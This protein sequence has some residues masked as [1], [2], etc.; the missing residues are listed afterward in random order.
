MKI[1]PI[2][3]GEVN[4]EILVL[5]LDQDRFKLLNFSGLVNEI[6]NSETANKEETAKYGTWL[7][8]NTKAEIKVKMNAKNNPK[9]L[10]E[11]FVA[12]SIQRI[13]A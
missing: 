13:L 8:L 12:D 11:L 2:I 4:F 5:N 10:S 1:I 7:C 3:T 9:V 6:R